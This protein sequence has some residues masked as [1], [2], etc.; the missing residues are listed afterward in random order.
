[1]SL[2]IILY[3]AVLSVF[4]FGYFYKGINLLKNGNSDRWEKRVILTLKAQGSDKIDFNKFRKY[5]WTLSIITGFLY[6]TILGL[7][8]V[9]VRNLAGIPETREVHFLRTSIIAIL[10]LHLSGNMLLPVVREKFIKRKGQHEAIKYNLKATIVYIVLLVVLVY[11][12]YT[13]LTYNW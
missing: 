11:S 3:L 6:L 5:S 8:F 13:Q 1:M 12:I 10:I 9:F 7:T 2:V 4:I